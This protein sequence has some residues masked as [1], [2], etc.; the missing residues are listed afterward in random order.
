MQEASVGRRPEGGSGGGRG[1]S[2]GLPALAAV[3]G[4]LGA[5]DS[6][7]LLAAMHGRMGVA[8]GVAVH[9]ALIAIAVASG[10]HCIVGD[11]TPWVVGLIATAVA[12]PLGA[13]GGLLIAFA[14]RQSR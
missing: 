14:A 7:L 5:C 1:V 6:L 8:Y 11:R 3:L 12:G 13:A 10:R 9:A 4:L 2:A